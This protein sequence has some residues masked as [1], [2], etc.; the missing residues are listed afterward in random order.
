MSIKGNALERILEID[1]KD[2]S[3]GNGVTVSINKLK[4]WYKKDEL[5]KTFEDLERLEVY[6]RSLEVQMQYLLAEFDQE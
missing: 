6:K 1:D 2:I 4:N 5:N 3:H